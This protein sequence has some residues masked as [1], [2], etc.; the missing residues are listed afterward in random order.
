MLGLHAYVQAYVTPCTLQR[1]RTSS[2]HDHFGTFM[3]DY[4]GPCQK[5][6]GTLGGVDEVGIFILLV[7]LILSRSRNSNA[8]YEQCTEMACTRYRTEVVLFVMYRTSHIPKWSR[9]QICR[10]S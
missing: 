10:K 1:D 3:Q 6:F 9:F 2:V 7:L 4:F 5:N 8:A